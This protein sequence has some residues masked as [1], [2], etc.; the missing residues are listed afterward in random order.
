VRA[1]LVVAF[2]LSGCSLSQNLG[3]GD[4][5][6]VFDDSGR[7]IRQWSF[8]SAAE[9]GAAGSQTESM[10]ID[11]RGSLTPHGYLYGALVARGV[12]GVKLWSNADADWS[13]L[14]T[15]TPLATGLWQGDD[16]A[17]DRDLVWVGITNT[18]MTSVWMEGE[19]WFNAGENWRITGNDTAFMYVSL[20]GKTFEKVVHNSMAIVQVPAAGWYPVRIGWADGDD[21]GDLTLQVDPT[22]GGSFGG[23]G[24]SR[25]RAVTS[26][27]RGTA[28]NV[29][30]REI[31]GGGRPGELPVQTIQ[32]T[33]LHPPTQFNPPLHGSVTTATNPFDWSVRWT[34]QL[35]VTTSGM[36][37]V[38]VQSND[39]SRAIVG[40]ATFAQGFAR[41]DDGAVTVT[42]TTPLVAGW[43]DLVVDFNHVDGTPAFDVSITAAPPEE[44]ALVGMPLPLDRLRPVEPRAD[45]LITR[46]NATPILVLDNQGSSFA[47]LTTRIDAHP[48]ETI[49]SVAITARVTTLAVDQLVYRLTIPGG[50]PQAVTMT[51]VPDGNGGNS[52]IAQGV[53]TIGAGMPAAGIWAFGIADASSANPDADSTF[54]ELHVTVHTANGPAQVAT[55][56]TWTSPIVENATAVSVIDMVNWT[57][58]VPAGASVELRMR[59]C[60]MAD[61]IDGQWSEPIAKTTAPALPANR[62]IQMQVTMTSDGTHEPEV[63][64]IMVQYRTDPK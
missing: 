32:Q 9:F 53:F 12:Q 55:A 50:T 33:A 22:G 10:T 21:S 47:A 45:R 25:L 28:R 4:A 15:V 7:E 51:E 19:I 38:R 62:Y 46:S 40:G 44:A 60:A 59:T 27:L 41:D 24:R 36:Y 6:P 26:G 17:V 48:G 16:L 14:A 35:Y 42:A 49:T 13:K 63:D 57:E 39:G 58:R 20:D 37:T 43:N 54:E 29:Y 61:C 64:A 1:L 3:G 5:K 2:A 23:V 30:Y 56:S 34:G 18:A 52:A 11:P 8:D 31:H